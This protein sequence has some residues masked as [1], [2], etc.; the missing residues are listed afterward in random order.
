MAL[1][2]LGRKR[3]ARRKPMGRRRKFVRR[4]RRADGGKITALRTATV[5]DRLILRMKY[6]DNIVLSGIGG[7]S[8]VFRLNSLYD[9][10][11]S[12]TNGHQPLGYDQWN[13]FYNKYRVFKAIVTIKA[14][15]TSSNSADAEQIGFV[16]G[17]D[18]AAPGFGDQFFEQ[19]HCKRVTISGRGGIDKGTI[20]YTVSIPRVMGMAS[21]V[22]KSNP[23]VASTFNNNPAEQVYGYLACRPLDGSSTSLV[24]CEVSIT[25]VC[26]LFD[27]SAVPVSYPA[28]KDPE[29]P[30]ATDGR[31]DDL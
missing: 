14:M 25:Y 18:Q 5:P 13:T 2:K 24:S 20:R 31:I 28:G 15:N 16:A 27:R 26:E 12:V 30:D 6:V 19:P 11:T 29:A 17:P 23:N 21:V 4:G 22:Y 7:A 8:R 3:V 10:D 9:P 1:R